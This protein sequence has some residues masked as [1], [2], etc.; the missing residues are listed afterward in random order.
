MYALE[1][2]HSILQKMALPGNLF[3]L[4]CKAA[5]FKE[6]YSIIDKMKEKYSIMDKMKQNIYSFYS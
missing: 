6:K 1:K 4:S 3:D 5:V 2:R